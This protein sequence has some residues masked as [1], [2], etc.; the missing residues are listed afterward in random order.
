MPVRRMQSSPSGSSRPRSS[1]ALGATALLAVGCT[2]K[3]PNYE[4]PHVALPATMP[5]EAVPSAP[6][7]FATKSAD[8]WRSWWTVFHD[9]ELE[10]LVA[11]TRASNLDLRAALDRVRAARA[12]VRGVRSPLFPQVFGDAGYA[13]QK[14]STETQSGQGSND[15]YDQWSASGDVAWEIDLFGRTARAVEAACADAAALEE[16]RRALELVLVADVAQTWFDV[17]AARAE[18]DIAKDTARLLEETLGLVKAKYDAGLT[19]ELDLRRTE[20]DLATA[21]ALIPEAERRSSVGEHRLAILLGRPPGSHFEAKPPAA[22]QI[23]P[24]VPVG[25]PA[26]LLE[27]RPDVRAAEM[28][29]VATNARLGQ[30]IAEFY[31][32]VTIVG[33]IA[34]SSVDAA[35]V[36]DPNALAWSIGPSIHIPIFEGGRL[37]AQRFQREAERDAATAAYAQVVYVALGEVADSVVGVS[38]RLASRDRQKEAVEAATKAVE[39]S[40]LAYEK[41]ITGYVNVLDGQRALA[42]ARL[43]LLN[44]QRLV[45]GD[46]I[47]LGK[48]LGGGWQTTP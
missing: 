14:N 31:P 37:A 17:G 3:G 6:K 35:T 2:V 21:R 36:F 45:I 15:S 23:P 13:R 47:R 19:T 34:T 29:L 40:N 12:I 38:A 33:R 30:A 46:L 11:E 25:L 5:G 26:A 16:D 22:F 32:S 28:R 24:E 42:V 4:R 7:L 27:R 44:A 1:L 18:Y 20:G 10:R 41:G 39:L 8:A 48:A 9:P 43:S